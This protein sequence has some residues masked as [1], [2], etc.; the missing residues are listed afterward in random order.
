MKRPDL[1]RLFG[2]SIAAAR[3]VGCA[4]RCGFETIDVRVT[5]AEAT[6][7]GSDCLRFC[8][9]KFA[10]A[11]IHSCF[12]YPLDGGLTITTGTVGVS[13]SCCNDVGG[14]GRRPF[15]LRPPGPVAA[16]SA[17]GTFLGR[18]AHL[19]AAAVPAFQRLAVEL[20]VH[21]APAGLV[22]QALQSAQD[23]RRHADMVCALAVHFGGAVAPVEIEVFR[24]R[25]MAEMVA[26]NAA[27]GC[28]R[29]TYGALAAAWMASAA[30]DADIRNTFASIARDELRHAELSWDIAAW[31][32]LPASIYE[33]GLE[34]LR[35]GISARP[36]SEISRL[37]GVPA[38][39]DAYRLWR[40]IRA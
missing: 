10:E 11:R 14:C 24:V 5:A 18:M 34:S 19:E 15:G 22:A 35:I 12:T 37:A 13:C 9:D 39:E 21:G 7:A 33:N 40:E 25:P 20:S 29:E 8:P 27:E 38:P 6:D 26:E 16:G 36:P 31:G 3:L 17:L 30:A 28:A 1:R 32:G 2:V 23:E 4:D